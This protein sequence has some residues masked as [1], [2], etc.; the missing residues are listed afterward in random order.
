MIKAGIAAVA[1]LAIAGGAL[2]LRPMIFGEEQEPMVFG[3]DEGPIELFEPVDCAYGEAPLEGTWSHDGGT[4]EA[5]SYVATP[6]HG[7]RRAGTSVF[8]SGTM[9][10]EEVSCD[11]FRVTSPTMTYLMRA[12][13]AGEAGVYRSTSKSGLASGSL[14]QGPAS[15]AWDSALELT[16]LDAESMA[17]TIELRIDA[18]GGNAVR[19]LGL[20]GGEM[21]LT[22]QGNEPDVEYGP[23][24]RNCPPLGIAADA[25]DSGMLP[26]DDH[27]LSLTYDNLIDDAPEELQEDL[28][29][30]RDAHAYL[31]DPDAWTG[32]HPLDAI[33]YDEAR[34]ALDNYAEDTCGITLPEPMARLPQDE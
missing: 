17:G 10:V 14:Q 16:V 26:A 20:G 13:N 2:V 24:K 27:N 28:E 4:S 32:P 23:D 6:L 19:G 8:P 9:T 25:F 31:D 5:E 3:E 29:V 1:V 33:A 12:V 22:F 30:L 18:A 11:G 34:T 7:A 21:M 15:V